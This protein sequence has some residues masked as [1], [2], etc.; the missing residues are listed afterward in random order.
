MANVGRVSVS[1]FFYGCR[2]VIWQEVVAGSKECEVYTPF[3][4]TVLL[5]ECI[6]SVTA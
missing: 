3:D 5:Q 1:K 2:R 6:A 4:W